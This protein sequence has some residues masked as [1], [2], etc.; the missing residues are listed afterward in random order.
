MSEVQKPTGHR[1]PLATISNSEGISASSAA[2]NLKSG[3][4]CGWYMDDPEMSEIDRRLSV[5]D[6]EPD[7]NDWVEVFSGAMMMVIGIY[8]IIY[9]GEII[10]EEVMKWFA[11]I[12]ISVG[13]VWAAHGLKDMAVKEVRRSIVMLDA[14]GKQ[15]SVDYGLIR[16]VLLHPKQYRSFLLEAYEKAYEDGVLSDEEVSELKTIQ[17]A[18]G[19]T[20]EEAAAIATRGAINAALKD[21]SVTEDEMT[22][23]L[24]AANNAGL[25]DEDCEK[26]KKALEDEKLDSDEKKMLD[27]ILGKLD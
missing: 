3:P 15:D 16:D 14:S 23:I 20:D 8:Y 6:E 21:G 22:L 17:S 10:S 26:I 4:Y 12:V 9:P 1:F 25:S 24:E 7:L 19:M 11:A 2:N 18:L 27:E 5:F 13:M